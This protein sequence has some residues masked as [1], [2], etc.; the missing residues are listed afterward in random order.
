[1]IRPRPIAAGLLAAGLWAA[2]AVAGPPDPAHVPADAKWMTH[3]DF[4]QLRDSK[5]LDALHEEK[6]G[7]CR[8]IRE[9][10]ENETGFTAWDQLRH[11]T[12][13]ATA[14]DADSIVAVAEADLPRNV[15]AAELKRKP[16]AETTRWRGHT[17]YTWEEP[18]REG[19]EFGED[20]DRQSVDTDGDGMPRTKTVAAALIEDGPAVFAKN[21]DRLKAAVDVIDGEGASLEGKNSE[22]LADVPDG[23]SVY[24]AAIELGSIA[25]RDG[26]F[27]ILRQHEKICYAIGHRD[28]KLFETVEL[29]ARDA[30]TAGKMQQF[31]KG[32]TALKDIYAADNDALSRLYD[33]VEVTRD[34]DTLKADFEA[35]VTVVLAGLE[36]LRGR[37]S[38]T[39]EYFGK[40]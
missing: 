30:E 8:A 24:G 5:L 25:R 4:D 20:R 17:L 26:V 16:A 34:G 33:G 22:L 23:S 10:V 40:D 36:A 38:R 15:V 9:D 7:M 37:M 6:P 32:L 21:L 19:D 35:D 31:L 18:M 29:V 27:P 2:P 12:L 39:R 13:F 11:V 3:F 14:Y 1:M 28:G